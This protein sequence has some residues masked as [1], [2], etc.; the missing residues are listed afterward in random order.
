MSPNSPKKHGTPSNRSGGGSAPASSS[1]WK[2]PLPKEVVA[3]FK[4]ISSV[5]NP[6]LIFERFAPDMSQANPREKSAW[7]AQALKIAQ[8][9]PDSAAL[10]AVYARWQALTEACKAQTFTLKTDWRFIPGLGRKTALEIGFSFHRYG[11]PYLPASSV[12]GIARTWALFEL[13]ALLALGEGKLNDLDQTL[14]KEDKE[15]DKAF[16]RF[17]PSPEAKELAKTIRLVFG[18]LDQAGG[19]IFFDAMPTSAFQLDMDIM[20]PHYAPYYQGKEPPGDWHN[21]NP[22]TFLAVP[23]DKEFAFAVAWRRGAPRADLLEQACT[24]LKNGLRDLGAGA[25]TSAGYG[26]FK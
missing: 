24:W 13:A 3:V 9:V 16:E 10:K 5:S 19:A 6:G 18:T 21:P 8:S 1:A 15:F 22:V 17:K 20:N 12:K 23:K 25:K 14:S 7:R 2:Y 4:S 26:Y 11:F